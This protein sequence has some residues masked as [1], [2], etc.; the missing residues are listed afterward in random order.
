MKIPSITAKI[1]LR[2]QIFVAM[3]F[4]VLLACLLILIATY[5]QYQNESEDYNLFRLNR[6]ES[7]LRNQISFLV[8]TNSLENKSDNYWLEHKDDFTAIMKIHNVNFSVFNLQGDALFN[9]FLPLEIIANNYKLSESILSEIQSN[10][11]NRVL[12]ENNDEVGKFQSSY[13]L[14]FNSYGNPYGVLFFPYFEDVSFSENELNKF[15]NSLYK[16]YL[17]M[18]IIAILFAYFISKYVTRPLETIRLKID[19][20]GLLEQNEKIYLKNATKEVFSLINSYNQMVDELEKSAEKLAIQEREQAWQEMA[21]QVA[22]EIKNPLTPMRL[23]VQSF[24]Q[25]FLK[26]KPYSKEKIKEFCDIL[27]EQIDTMKDVANTFS[28]FAALPEAKLKPSDIVKISKRSLEIFERNKI[29]FLSSHPEIFVNLDRTQW[30]R[31][32]TNL[33]QNGIQSVPIE[34]NA[35]L[36]VEIK[37]LITEVQI[38]FIDNGVGIPESIKDKIFEPK[39]TTKTKGMG[40]GLGIVKNIIDSHGGKIN[41]SSSSKGTKFIITLKI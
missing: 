28:D 19:Q 17:A 9:S 3:I 27:I 7:Q 40:L 12:K 33:I 13:S 23:T 39:F 20:T 29:E 37:K 22:H 18:L 2:N 1:S 5:F 6:K 25:R 34:A 16:I 15:L 10:V 35:K 31:V 26:N 4:L 11:E 21:K 30:V 36:K 38:I 32:M 41:Y 24:E 14:L 8:K